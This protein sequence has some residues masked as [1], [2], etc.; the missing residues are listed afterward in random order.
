MFHDHIYH[1][2]SFTNVGALF[3][4]RFISRMT[5][6]LRVR[7]FCADLTGAQ[8][9]EADL[10]RRLAKLPRQSGL[11]IASAT[12]ERHRLRVQ[13]HRS[14]CFGYA[15]MTQFLSLVANYDAYL[16][17]KSWSRF[18]NIAGFL[19]DASDQKDATE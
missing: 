6:T 3:P 7:V 12:S 19:L 16:P 14:I 13:R 1:F 4:V 5:F 15:R 2:F 11:P 10:L 18:E 8:Q 9:D 17:S